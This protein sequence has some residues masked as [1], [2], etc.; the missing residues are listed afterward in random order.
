MYNTDVSKR[1]KDTLLVRIS[2]ARKVTVWHP[3]DI[4]ETNKRIRSMKAGVG[5]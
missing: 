4:R 3:H 1:L 2:E 5:K